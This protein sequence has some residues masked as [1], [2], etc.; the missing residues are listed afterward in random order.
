[1]SAEEKL[2]QLGLTLPLPAPPLANYV[3]YVQS[4]N[5]LFVSGQLAFDSNGKLDSVHIGK[6]GGEVSQADGIAAA[7]RCAINIL[8]QAKVALGSLDH[9]QR[10]IK[11]G[12]FVNVT[13]DFVAMP[14]V[15]NG[16]SDLMVAVLG[17][18]GRHARA[19][20]GVASLPLNCAIEVEAV[21]EVA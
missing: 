4:G 21:F 20:V 3:G 9:I 16:A 15:M 10:C 18:K 19:V 6:L 8:A 13:G 2:A 11:L 17:D 12:G 7:A 5:L 14:A 1:M